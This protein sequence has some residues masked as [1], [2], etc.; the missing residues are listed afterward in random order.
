MEIKLWFRQECLNFFLIV[1]ATRRGDIKISS[2]R[3]RSEKFNIV[4]KNHGRTQKCNFC[5]SVCKT[6]FTDLMQ[7]RVYIFQFWSVNP[8]CKRLQWLDYMKRNHYK[9]LLNVFSS[10]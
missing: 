9:M 6:D 7:Y 4:S 8:R 1:S 10:T 2:V 3:P 5:V